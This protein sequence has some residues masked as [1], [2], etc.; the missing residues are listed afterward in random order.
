[1][2]I[3]QQQ[4]E[5][6]TATTTTT[7]VIGSFHQHSHHM[8]SRTPSSP[9]T[10]R[11]ESPSQQQPLPYSSTTISRSGSSSKHNIAFKPSSLTQ[12]SSGLSST[13]LIPSCRTG[14]STLG[15]QLDEQE[16]LQRG[17]Y[18]VRFVEL[19]SPSALAGLKEGDRVTKINGKPT[20]GM[21]FEEFCREIEIAQQKQLQ[22]NM[23]H[24]MV[25]RKSAKSTGTSSYSAIT[26]ATSMSATTA[27]NSSSAASASTGTVLPIKNAF[28]S[29]RTTTTTTTSSNNTSN[30]IISIFYLQKI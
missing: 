8:Y 1:M 28:S 20:P 7:N 3:Y 21:G 29:S 30:N 6:Y 11:S 5:A 13:K 4:F 23:I 18:V 27:T 14:N 16:M 26:S 24:L 2:P 12:L 25:L 15:F 17:L 9:P 10:L 19:N 22:N